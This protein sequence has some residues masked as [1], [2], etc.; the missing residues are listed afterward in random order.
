MNNVKKI[1]MFLLVFMLVTSSTLFFNTK[2]VQATS[3]Q[4][5]YETIERD[6]FQDEQ[7]GPTRYSYSNGWTSAP[8]VGTG[9]FTSVTKEFLGTTTVNH[10]T[11]S[12]AKA[13]TKI[14]K[15]AYHITSR[16]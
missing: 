5:V 2:K 11:Y 9:T 6:Y 8:Q 3:Y 15:Y 1:S 4:T 13:Y 10:E 12:D 16:Y 7:V 14:T